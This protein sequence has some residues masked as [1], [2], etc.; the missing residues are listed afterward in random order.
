M[1]EIID[2]LK[3]QTTPISLCLSGGGGGSVGLLCETG[4]ASHVFLGAKIPY[5]SRELEKIIGSFEKA[6]SL[7]TCKKMVSA[8]HQQ[9]QFTLVSTASLAKQNQRECRMNHAYIGIDDSEFEPIF[10]YIVFYPT[11]PRLQQERDLSNL[12]LLW[13]QED[14]TIPE[15]L[16]QVKKYTKSIQTISLI[17]DDTYLKVFNRDDENYSSSTEESLR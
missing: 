7:E 13:S 8:E 11:A 2:K 9:G 17:C 4:G 1:D 14:C 10:F 3:K 15:V 12:I 16:G 5:S 6:C